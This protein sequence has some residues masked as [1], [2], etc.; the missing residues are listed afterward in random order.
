MKKE[1]TTSKIANRYYE[2]A[3]DYYESASILFINIL[4][5]SSIYNPTIYLLR[6]SVELF[7]KGLIIK[8]N[9][10]SNN[11]INID[12]IKV[13]TDSG[14]KKLNSIHSLWCLWDNYKSLNTKN[15]LI[16]IFDNNQEKYL[17]KIIASFNDKDFDS[18]NF[19]YPYDKKGEEIIIKPVD[20]ENIKY[21]PDISK[22]K[23]NLIEFGG[24]V[25]EVKKGIKAVQELKHLFIVAEQ[26]K[27]F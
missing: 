27:K 11:T 24:N 22:K 1:N 13:N 26:L 6:H 25:Y 3:L 4:D 16:S 9:I 23:L 17:D 21:A 2:L 8:E 7:L 10:I 18:T 12:E 19:R 14:A 15:R 5:N 20:I